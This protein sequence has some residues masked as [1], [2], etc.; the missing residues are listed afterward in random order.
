VL[1]GRVSTVIGEVLTD[2][3]PVDRL[4]LVH[5]I[6][7]GN[8]AGAAVVPVGAAGVF[9]SG[10]QSLFLVAAF[11][12]LIAA[13]LTWYFVSPTETPP[14]GAPADLQAESAR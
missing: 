6:T 12:M 1:Y 4:R 9:A 7:A 3:A 10:Y 5:D 13:S 2:A 14:L 8:L 11:F